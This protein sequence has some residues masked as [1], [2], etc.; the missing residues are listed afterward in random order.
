[1][2][3][4]RRNINFVQVHCMHY[5]G[6]WVLLRIY[7][8]FR[9]M[10]LALKEISIR[11]DFRTTV[12]YLIKLLEHEFF[13][14]NKI[15]TGWLDF[16]ISKQDQVIDLRLSG[17]ILPIIASLWISKCNK[18]IAPRRVE[19]M[20]SHHISSLVPL[21][22]NSE[23]PLFAKAKTTILFKFPLGWC[24]VYVNLTFAMSCSLHDLH[25]QR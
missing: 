20:K 25:V 12:E 6:Y 3:N 8:S 10:V 23:V 7:F 19:R 15:D 9:N 4:D 22:Q 16:L 2:F 5:C 14:N 13:S 11:G 17:Y 21:T 24:R 18:E 1:M